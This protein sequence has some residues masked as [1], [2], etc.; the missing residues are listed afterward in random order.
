MIG[1]GFIWFSLWSIFGSLIGSRINLI[2]A[3]ADQ[4]WLQSWERTLLR[5]TH[6][7]MNSMAIIIVLMGLSIKSAARFM[8]TKTLY[9][10]CFSAALSVPIFGAGLIFEAFNAPQLGKISSFTAITALGGSLFLFA[11]GTWGALFLFHSR[12]ARQP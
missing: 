3:S 4:L 10:T 9:I 12:T 11:V 2:M 5:T 1:V 8:S 6:A 7:H